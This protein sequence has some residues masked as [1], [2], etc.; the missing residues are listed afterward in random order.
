MTSISFGAILPIGR[1]LELRDIAD[2]PAKWA[3]TVETARTAEAL[4]YDSVWVYDHFH[5]VPE[6][7]HETV[8]ESWTVLAALTQ[9][10]ER[11]RLGQMVACNLARSPAL[12]A[13]IAAT[14]DV[15]S[16]GRL[17]WGIGAGWDERELRAYGYEFPSARVR[18][19]MLDEAVD[20]VRAL[21]TQPDAT[22]AGRHF[23]LDGAQCDPN[24]I[25]QPH[26][27]I[28]IGGAGERRTLRV[29]ARQADCS[30]FGG[31]PREWAHKSEVLAAHCRDVGR[32]YDEITR[33]WSHDLLIRETEAEIDAAGSLDLWGASPEA[34]RDANLVGTPD[35]VAEQVQRYV[36]TGCRAFIV[37]CT[38]YPSHESLELFAKRVIPNFR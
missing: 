33:T 32:D 29:V 9:C 21:W 35:Q 25:Q 37:W 16:G 34:W 8:F 10:T 38:D 15:M 24:P 7:S 14:V 30:N 26:P 5:N 11:V 28:W 18:V 1:R 13:K 17:D 3:T 4:G 6:P 27:P 36:D 19:Q 23:R 31:S 12:V 22:Y 20:V 2:V